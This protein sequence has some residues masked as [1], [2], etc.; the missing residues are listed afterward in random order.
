MLE[1]F[2]TY[3]KYMGKRMKEEEIEREKENLFP[4]AKK[5]LR[6]KIGNR[7]FFRLHENSIE[8]KSSEWGEWETIQKLFENQ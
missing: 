3:K 2:G 4:E 6:R 8:S 5:A 7:I 1:L